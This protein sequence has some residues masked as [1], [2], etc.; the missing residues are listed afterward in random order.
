MLQPC[1]NYAARQ[2]SI[3]VSSADRER[4]NSILTFAHPF[5]EYRLAITLSGAS[6][7]ELSRL[8]FAGNDQC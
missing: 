7:L 1:C 8:L 6:M 5:A 2:Y 3:L 4:D